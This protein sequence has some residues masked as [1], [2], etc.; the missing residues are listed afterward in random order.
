MRRPVVYIQDTELRAANAGGLRTLAGEGLCALCSMLFVASIFCSLSEYVIG[1]GDVIQVSVWRYDQFSTTAT[2]G[3]DGKIT[4]HLL[5]DITVTGLTREEIKEDITKRLSKFIKEGA[6][7]TVSVVQFNSQKISVFGAVA[8]PTTIAFSS[9]PSLLEIVMTR[10]I[11][12][13]DADLTAVKIIPADSSIREPITV[14][15]MEVLQKGNTS[16]MPTLHA[17]DTVYVPR[18]ETTV[19]AVEEGTAEGQ[20]QVTGDYGPATSSQP[21]GEEAQGGEFVVYIMGAVARPGSFTSTEEP[22]LTQALLEAGSVTDSMAL[23]DIRIIRGTQA[24]MP[25]PPKDDRVIHVDLDKYLAEG[26]ASLLP[27]LYSGDTIYVPNITQ[28]AMKDVSILVTGE[29]TRPGSYQTREPLDILDAI[30]MAGGLTRNADPE[31]IRIRRESDDS[32]QEKV[33]NIDEF[34]KDVSSTSPSEMVEPGY[35]IYVPAK[36]G[37]I[38]TVAVATRGIAA[39]LVDLIPIYS[40]WRLARGW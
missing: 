22:T 2:V 5:G 34:L 28:E 14:N 26:D 11:P 8:N 37:S 29:V 25:V 18:V 12:T 32:Y 3:P 33:V 1:P 13:P 20:P 24:A 6:E 16:Q 10:S 4:I 40:L 30:S 23:K 19:E 31:R 38:A 9:I 7:V 15:M 27:R 39:F 36:R 35:R 17:G 21:P